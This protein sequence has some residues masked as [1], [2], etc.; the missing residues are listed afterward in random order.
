MAVGNH[1]SIVK[2]TRKKLMVKHQ[3]LENVVDGQGA[4]GSEINHEEEALRQ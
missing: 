2:P 1:V 3:R 4:I